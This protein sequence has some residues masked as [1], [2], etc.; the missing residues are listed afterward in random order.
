[1][2]IEDTIKQALKEQGIDASEAIAK[3]SDDAPVEAT[4]PVEV[5]DH[6]DREFS[7]FE[8]EQ[9]AKGWNPDGVKSAEEYSRTEPLY[10]EIKSRGKQLKQM[11]KAIDAL[12]AHMSKQEKIAYDKALNTLRQERHEAIA[13]GD[14]RDVER[15]EAETQ[16]LLTPPPVAIPEAE[17]FKEKYEHIFN[18]ANYEEMEI[19]KFLHERDS[20]LMA[21][22]LSPAEH[23]K[24]LEQ[25]ML[26]KFPSYFGQKEVVS[27]NET[28][29]VETGNSSNVVKKSSKSRFSLHDLSVEQKQ[30]ARDFEKFGIMKVD[31]YIKQLVELG[32]L[33]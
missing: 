14:I 27:R 1:M 30:V 17:V 26:K 25:H 11:Q 12:T 3:A 10:E 19:V 16:Q 9:M 31:E 7:D 6:A 24:T 8:R 22:G 4:T 20:E 28:G 5:S 21:R 23:M 18:S 32:E 15:I 13:R 29:Y 2:S 33:K